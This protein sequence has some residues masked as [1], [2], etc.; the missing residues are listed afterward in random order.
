MRSSS[1][2][3]Y[4]TAGFCSAPQ[5]SS[6]TRTGGEKSLDW[7]QG[8]WIW[9]TPTFSVCICEADWQGWWS[10]LVFLHETENS[11]VDF[12]FYDWSMGSEWGFWDKPSGKNC[13]AFDGFRFFVVSPSGKEEGHGDFL[14]QTPWLTK[15]HTEEAML[16]AV[17]AKQR[18]ERWHLRAFLEMLHLLAKGPQLHLH[19]CRLFTC[20]L[21]PP[22]LHVDLLKGG[23][24]A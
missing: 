19:F 6:G 18:K 15:C 5:L 4:L 8:T 3:Q 11:S 21:Y 12:M 16:G 14:C 24:Y 22:R 10:V 7:I 17:P 13:D 9:A 1:L 20:F 23:K 2:T